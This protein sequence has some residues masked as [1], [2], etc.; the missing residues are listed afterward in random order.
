MKQQHIDYQVVPYP[1]IRRFMAAAFRSTHRTPIM[2]GLIEV[3]VTRAR[4]PC[5]TIKRKPG[6][7]CRSRRSSLPAWQKPSMSTK[8]CRHVAKAASTSS[9]LRMWTCMTYIERDVAGQTHHAL[10]HPSSQSQ[11]RARNSSGDQGR[12]GAGRGKSRG[13]F[14]IGS[15]PAYLSLQTFFWVSPGS[16]EVST[17]EEV[18][19]DGG[20][21]GSGHVWERCRLGHPS[22]PPQHSRLRWVA[23][24]RSRGS[25]TGR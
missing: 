18:R 22:S 3:D 19:G 24:A 25:W 1:K 20:P 23:L 4:A 21:H 8:P 7:P 16:G 15:V 13:G 5:G 12:P 17:D 14:Q 6:R 2:H 9:C 10:H 11:D